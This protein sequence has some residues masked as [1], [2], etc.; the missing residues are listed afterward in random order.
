M[1]YLE[2]RGVA[3]VFYW[4]A[5]RGAIEVGAIQAVVKKNNN[6]TNTLLGKSKNIT[7]YI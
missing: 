5:R 7:Q 2:S 1:G 6:L 3:T 4:G